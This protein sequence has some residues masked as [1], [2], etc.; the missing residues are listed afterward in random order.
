MSWY[1]AYMSTPNR[2]KDIDRIEQPR[3]KLAAYGAEK[4]TDVDLMA[5]ILRTGM[6]G[7]SVVEVSKKLLRQFPG[8]SLANAAVA[9]I[10]KLPG[11]GTVKAQELV[12]CFELGRRFL[13]DKQVELVLSP[14]V[15]WEKMEG[16]RSSKKEHFVVFFLDTQSQLIHKDTVS[17][18]TLNASLIH[19]REVFEPAVRH[20]ASHI[21]VAHNHPSGGLEPSSEDRVVTRRL[22]EAGVLLGIQLIDHVIVTFTSYYSFKEQNEL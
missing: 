1:A 18:G 21:I 19:P 13:K 3:E 5:I 6:Q 9:D 2:L 22:K 15:V 8:T 20:V 12:A 16:I 17:V 11:I 7:R 14:R 4:L 10:A